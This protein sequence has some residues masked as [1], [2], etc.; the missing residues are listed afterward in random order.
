V[1]ALGA[2]VIRSTLTTYMPA[3]LVAG[4]ICLVAALV[5]LQ[6]GPRAPSVVPAGE[7]TG[8]VVPSQL[9]TLEPGAGCAARA[10]LASRPPDAE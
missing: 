4:A 6:I 5:V 9:E 3:W 8:L 2:R 10:F 1:G 7:G